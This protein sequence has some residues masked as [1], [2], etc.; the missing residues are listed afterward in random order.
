MA[1]KERHT[2][3]SKTRRARQPKRQ[4]ISPRSRGTPLETISGPFED[5]IEEER[6]RL[7]VAESILHC[8]ALVMN[9]SDRSEADL[10]D[11]E[12]IVEVARQMVRKSIN[13]LD[14]VNLRCAKRPSGT[15][16]TEKT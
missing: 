8:A 10:P 3:S 5:A 4:R 9:E 2:V 11:F 14:S 15:P 12:S 7:M 6:G 1:K 13:Q 16:A